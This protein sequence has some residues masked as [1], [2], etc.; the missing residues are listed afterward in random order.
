[1]SKL[2]KLISILLLGGWFLGFVYALMS[3]AKATAGSTFMSWYFTV[4]DA[5]NFTFAILCGIPVLLLFAP[6][7]LLTEWLWDKGDAIEDRAERAGRAEREAVRMARQPPPP[8]PTAEQLTQL[9]ER[10]REGSERTAAYLASYFG[11]GGPSPPTPSRR[12]YPGQKRR[13]TRRY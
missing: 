8:P 12:R 1:M 3:F 13:Q 7:G 11:P 6:V 5:N 9:Q 10:T 2:L 4:A